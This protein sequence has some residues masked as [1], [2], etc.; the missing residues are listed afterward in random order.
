MNVR[1]PFG[2]RAPDRAFATW[3]RRVLFW[4]AAGNIGRAATGCVP[5][6]PASP[7]QPGQVTGLCEDG[8]CAGAGECVAGLC[9]DPGGTANTYDDRAGQTGGALDD[10]FDTG[11]ADNGG[12]GSGASTNPGGDATG[13]AVDSTHG[14]DTN[15]SADS[16]ASAADGDDGG[17]SGGTCDAFAQDCPEGEKCNPY[18][19][20]GGSA[21][22]GATCVDVADSPASVGDPCTVVGSAASGVDNCVLGAMCWNVDPETNAGTCIELCSGSPANPSCD[23]PGSICVVTNMGFLPLC[24]L[25]C[26]PIVQGCDDREGCYPADDAFV[27]APDASGDAGGGYGSAC[28][29]LNACD[30]GLACIQASEV[31]DCPGASC[32]SE[33]CELDGPN[34]CSG[35]ASGMECVAWFADGDA[36]AGLDHVGACAIPP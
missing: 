9:V 11:H 34:M 27:C 17:G 22:D 15:A 32:C 18:A 14:S 4:L 7:D 8:Q 31:P 3:S 33:F 5:P 20:N 1:A 30:P 10:G 19:A 12:G 23:T 2:S 36:P 29:F 24:A 35:S 28:G 25:A 26:D 21:W 16:A 6:L 13:D